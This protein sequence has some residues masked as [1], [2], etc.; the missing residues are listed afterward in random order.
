MLPR[1]L[2]VRCTGPA[3]ERRSSVPLAEG[4]STAWL[5]VEYVRART[6][7]LSG[8]RRWQVRSVDLP[9]VIVGG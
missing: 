8:V 3:G 6:H 5:I 4:V 7:V 1:L 2:A 9:K